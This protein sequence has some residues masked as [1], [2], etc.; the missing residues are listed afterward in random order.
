M[1]KYLP[2]IVIYVFFGLNL[3]PQNLKKIDTAYYCTIINQNFEK[4]L[5]KFLNFEDSLR[6]YNQEKVTFRIFVTEFIH[7]ND[8]FSDS[9]LFRK[10]LIGI[11]SGIKDHDPFYYDTD[12]INDEKYF[13]LNYKRRKIVLIV[14]NNMS[15][16]IKC[17]IKIDNSLIIKRK[18]R[19]KPKNQNIKD[20]PLTL[21]YIEFNNQC[22]ITNTAFTFEGE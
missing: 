2:F 7:Y 22:E 12:I 18:K 15:D 4:E 17:F 13:I 20:L 5:I 11:Y 19:P 9:I 6:N 10:N 3:Y 8:S 14:D 21:F 16:K 1:K